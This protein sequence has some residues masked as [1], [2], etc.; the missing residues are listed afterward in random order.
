MCRPITIM[1]V[2]NTLTAVMPVTVITKVGLEARSRYKVRV[3]IRST[4]SIAGENLSIKSATLVAVTGLGRTQCVS[5]VSGPSYF[6]L[7]L[8]LRS[9]QMIGVGFTKSWNRA[10]CDVAIYIYIYL[11]ST[12]ETRGISL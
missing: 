2:I 1:L 11:H 3:S 7:L 4:P 10:W 5:D 8:L 9:K 6:L 12:Q